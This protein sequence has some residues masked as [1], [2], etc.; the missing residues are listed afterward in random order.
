[1]DIPVDKAHV[2]GSRVTAPA[3]P[4]H[5]DRLAKF[6]KV[7][8]TRIDLESEPRPDATCPK[9]QEPDSWWDLA[10]VVSTTPAWRSRWVLEHSRAFVAIASF[11]EKSRKAS[12]RD[13]SIHHC[14]Q[15][16][17]DV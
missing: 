17:T 10:P 9:R 3:W 5:P 1:V 4:A 6:L 11:P 8:G 15:S 14:L 13:F 12:L 2:D 16:P 7:L